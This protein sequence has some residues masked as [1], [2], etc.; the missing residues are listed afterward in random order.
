MLAPNLMTTMAIIWIMNNI[1][2]TQSSD[3]KYSMTALND[4]ESIFLEHL[5]RVRIFH[6]QWKIVVDYDF[7]H[8][9][10][11]LQT[12]ED[13]Y[14]RI[15][16]GLS[17]RD[18]LG[19]KFRCSSG[20]RL[21]KR[22][23]FF[24]HVRG[25]LRN[26]FYTAGIDSS[27]SRARRGIFDFVG[28]ISKTLF[29]T[30]DASDA[31]YYNN[32]LDKLYAYQKT[33]INYIR[34]QTSIVLNAVK[35]NAA[36]FNKTHNRI[37][38]INTQFN[39]LRNLSK[40]NEMNI[41]IDEIIMDLEQSIDELREQIRNVEDLTFDAKHGIVKPVTFSNETLSFLQEFHK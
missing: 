35:T 2:T 5:S 16:T 21:V 39:K 15:L 6:E 14:Q 11:D 7:A 9:E 18:V 25:E 3:E 17:L 41:Q 28:E 37:E 30:L 27:S 12:I 22:V 10:T 1:S 29:G 38:S 20:N 19:A 36:L 13:L 26:A 4:Q 32:E 31:Q 34:N 33:V 8:I 24:S 23:G 40:E